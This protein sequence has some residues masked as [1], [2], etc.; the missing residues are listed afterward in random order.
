M[1]QCTSGEDPNHRVCEFSSLILHRGAAYYLTDGV[2]GG[3]LLCWSAPVWQ[4]AMY[5]M[6]LASECPIRRLLQN[7]RTGCL[8][9]TAT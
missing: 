5:E 9:P 8:L 3:D 4:C 2:L 6:Q 1:L 7:A